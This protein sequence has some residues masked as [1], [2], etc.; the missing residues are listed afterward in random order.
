METE[1]ESFK[2]EL[3]MEKGQIIEIRSLS[4]DVH[5]SDPMP[6]IERFVEE[7]KEGF[8]RSLKHGTIM[9]MGQNSP[10]WVVY[11]TPNGYVKVWR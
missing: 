8:M 9:L 7:D 10:G 2:L 11:L 1:R 5:V 6:S 4:E 3:I